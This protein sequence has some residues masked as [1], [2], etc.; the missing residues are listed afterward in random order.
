MKRQ[1]GFGLGITSFSILTAGPNPDT[2]SD[3]DL[4]L[5]LSRAGGTS[6]SPWSELLTD[7]QLSS[8][9]FGGVWDSVNKLFIMDCC[10]AYGFWGGL[11][12]DH[13]SAILAACGATIDSSFKVDWS[14][15]QWYAWGFMGRCLRD[16]LNSLHNAE[17]ISFAQLAA[18]TKAQWPLNSFIYD[19]YLQDLSTNFAILATNVWLPVAANTSDFAMN[20]ILVTNW[21]HLSFSSAHPLTSNGL[22]LSLDA[23]PGL[24]CSMEVS[25]NLVSWTTLTNFVTTNSTMYFRD[26]SATS[27]NRRFYRAVVP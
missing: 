16:A 5:G 22:D 7:D 19:S 13:P 23:S 4:V 10:K 12:S 8:L 27:F 18:A 6:D 24:N 14:D 26:S 15:G 3:A 17:T 11:K 20:L 21:M 1:S 2:P 25:T 9:F